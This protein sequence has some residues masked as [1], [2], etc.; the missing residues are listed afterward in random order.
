MTINQTQ[1]NDVVFVE[2]VKAGKKTEYVGRVE[3][4]TPATVGH[5]ARLT[6]YVGCDEDGPQYRSFLESRINQ[7]CLERRGE[8]A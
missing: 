4:I 8:Y 2:Y 1:V 7:L 5:D 6:V 3:T